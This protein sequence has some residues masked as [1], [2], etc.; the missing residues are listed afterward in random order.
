MFVIPIISI[1][2]AYT[3]RTI[4]KGVITMMS[5]MNKLARF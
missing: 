3:R 5:S 2:M 4:L 1:S